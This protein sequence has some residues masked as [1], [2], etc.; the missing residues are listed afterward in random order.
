MLINEL[1]SFKVKITPNAH[2][3]YGTWREGVHDDLVLAVALAYWIGENP[4]ESPT[5]ITLPIEE[6][7]FSYD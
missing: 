2:D 3:T 1:L 6:G 4:T 5:I 7:V